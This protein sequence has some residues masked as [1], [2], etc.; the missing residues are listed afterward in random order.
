MNLSSFRGEVPALISRLRVVSGDG[1][2]DCICGA[3]EIHSHMHKLLRRCS[4][5][6]ALKIRDYRFS[7]GV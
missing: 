3:C 1:D 5:R 7:Q 4:A 6:V 2:D